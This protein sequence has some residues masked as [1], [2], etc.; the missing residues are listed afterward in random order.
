MGTPSTV[1]FL[2]TQTEAEGGGAETHSEK[3]R[4]RESEGDVHACSEPETNVERDGSS[5]RDAHACSEPETTMEARARAKQR[6]NPVQSTSAHLHTHPHHTHNFQGVRFNFHGCLILYVKHVIRIPTTWCRT[7]RYRAR[8]S[9]ISHG[10]HHLHHRLLI[11]CHGECIPAAPAH[12]RRS[13]D[14]IV[15]ATGNTD[16]SK[17]AQCAPG[18]GHAQ[19]HGGW[20]SGWGGTA[21]VRMQQL[22]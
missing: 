19:T 17:H 21:G 4:Q 9:P 8:R 22:A 16:G 6:K 15:R 14:A 7:H 1:R 12:R 13:P 2:E 10:V 20:G 5:Q 11:H 3:Q 18:E